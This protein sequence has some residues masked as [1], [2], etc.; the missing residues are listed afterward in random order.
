MKQAFTFIVC[1]VWAIGTLFADAPQRIHENERETPFPQAFHTLYLNPSPLLIPEKMN[2]TGM[3][4]FNL[5]QSKKFDTAETIL[6]QPQPWCMFN[7]HKKLETGTW[8][9]RVRCI[10]EDGKE[11]PWSQTFSFEVTEE[12]PVIATPSFET[13]R[14]NHPALG[15][16]LYGFHE[17]DLE[18]GRQTCRSNPEFGDMITRGRNALAVDLSTDTVPSKHVNRLFNHAIDLH[19]A[20]ILLDRDIY[21][22]KMVQYARWILAKPIPAYRLQDDF[23]AGELVSMLAC[24]YETCF[25]RL[26]AK[27]Q[28]QIENQIESVLELYYP[29]RI[30][31]HEE[32][33]IFDNH[34]WQFTFRYFL[35]GALAIYDKS[36]LAKEYVAYSYELWTCRAPASGFNRDGNWHNGTCYFSANAVSLYYIAKLFSHLTGTDFLQ[37]PWYQN[38]GQAMVYSWMPESMSVGFG[39][40]HEQM[41]DKPLMIRS[42]FADFIARETGNPYAAWY[43]SINDRYLIDPEFRL[44]RMT[45]T[46]QRPTP[47]LPAD[48]DKA[49]WFK[50]TGEMIANSDMADYRNNLCLSFHSSP[51]GSGSH[52][53]SNQNAFN[54]H[55]RG[56]PVYRAA[57]YYSNFSD[58]HNLLS[59]RNTRGHNTILIDGIGQPFT[60]RAYGNIVRMFNGEHI[61]YALGDASQAYCGISEYP[62][63]EANFKRQHLEQSPENGFGPTPLKKYR[64]H[65]F[66]LHPDIVVIYD[67]LEAEREVRW[68]WLLH[69]PVKFQIDANQRQLVTRNEAKDFTSTAYIFSDTA[70]DIAQT[71]SFAASPDIRKAV[72]GETFDK[73][74][75]LSASFPSQKANRILTV[76]QVKDGQTIGKAERQGNRVQIGG[77][78][79]EAELNP[80]KPVRILI[81][82]TNND[83]CFGYGVKQLTTNGNSTYKCQQK[84]NSVLYDCINGEWNTMET[85]DRAAL[86][87]GSDK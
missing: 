69:S 50:D 6:S 56:V 21:A 65:I 81:Q 11:L 54:L 61:S 14:S 31:R 4:Q 60:T 82:N 85:S 57:G 64:R 1:C 53:H 2:E 46:K 70:C 68:D 49:V 47:Q 16:R 59:Y 24:V 9:W 55:F 52:T 22:D 75:A 71:D 87:T 27:E 62:M 80:K 15:S 86:L 33:H 77:W 18:H 67:E 39:D 5:S 26:S 76:I 8:Y 78:T 63:W 79:I 72:R 30:L 29:T 74:W 37:H 12:I 10:D 36:D 43:S 34:F 42:A 17:K 44:Y 19:T 40:G 32:T 3:V 84:E 35:Q 38:V 48:A 25:D 41:N 66:M 83:A 58:A 45:T 7:P 73:Q 28:K 23:Y 51:F 20:Y 13:F